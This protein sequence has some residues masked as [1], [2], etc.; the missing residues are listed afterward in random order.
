MNRFLKMGA[1]L[2]SS[3]MLCMAMGVNVQAEPLTVTFVDANKVVT[4]YVE[5]GQ[6]AVPPTDVNVPGFVF[7]G[8][9]QNTNN[10]Q[11]N[12]TA[13][14][15]YLPETAGSGAIC[16]TW[17][18]LPNGVLSY[19]TN[20][21]ATL[22]LSAEQLRVTPTPMTAA[23]RLTAEQVVA[24]NPVGVPGQ[25]CVVRWYNGSTGQCWGADVVPYGTSLPQPAD[26]CM[27]GLEFVGWDGSWTN[28][29]TDRTITACYYKT[30][31]V[32]YVCGI[33]SE[34]QDVQY[35]RQTDGAGAAGCK[36]HSHN[37]RTFHYW[38]DPQIQ[39]DGVTAVI[40]SVY[41]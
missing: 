31:R 28:I 14:A 27:G 36:A 8:W 19:T 30:Y 11:G 23:G 12:I 10:V 21:S 3:F 32:K 13:Q 20:S 1:M 17:Q 35:I 5:R 40:V 2:A 16:T 29:T 9:S 33:C 25:T 24:M 37:G 22:P 6:N 26:P 41:K 4:Q 7:C 18:T 34:V 39:E 15:V 38:S